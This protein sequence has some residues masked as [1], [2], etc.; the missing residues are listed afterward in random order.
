VGGGDPTPVR[1][2]NGSDILGEAGRAV[3]GPTGSFH[4]TSLK[5]PRGP[6]DLPCM[7]THDVHAARARSRKDGQ[8]GRRAVIA[9][10]V[11]A[12]CLAVGLTVPAGAATPWWRRTTTTTRPTTTTTVKP[13]TTTT[14]KPTTTTTA[15]P[16]TTTAAPTTTTTAPPVDGTCGGT[17]GLKDDGSAWQ[18]SFDDEFNGT[19]VDR[20]NW[21]VQTT[22][23]S[24][25]HSGQECFVDSPNNVDV[26]GGDLHLT[27]RQEAAPFACATPSSSYSTQYTSGTVVTYGKFSQTYGRFE[28]RA[29]LPG[30]KVKGLQEAFWLWPDSPYKYGLWPYSGEIDFAEIYSQ[31]PDRAIP[32]IHYVPGALDVNVTNNYCLINDITQYHTYAAEWTPTTITIKYDGQTCLVDTWNPKSPL[33]KPA[34]FDQPFMI[35]LTQALGI[36]GN[37]FNAATTPLPATTSVDYVRAWK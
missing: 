21:L 7:T 1:D 15:Q 37:A 29:K 22:A 19:S 18:C 2:P 23:S 33:L 4:G 5:G 26:S 9:L 30:A 12:S 10:V 35:A 31:Y 20:S 14:V 36:G 16:T 3:H 6:V 27:V 34:P 28:V 32:Y 8:R 11:S 17:A 25:Y 13:T 24:G